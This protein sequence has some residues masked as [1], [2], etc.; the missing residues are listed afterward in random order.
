MIKQIKKTILKNPQENKID[1]LENKILELEN[2]LDESDIEAELRAL[3]TKNYSNGS[4][5]SSSDIM[6]VVGETINSATLQRLYASETW[7]FIVIHTIAKTISTLPI[8]LEKR[9]IQKQILTDD[10]GNETT[11][12]KETWIDASAEPEYDLLT[13]PNQSQ[14]PV[15]FYMLVLIDLLA[16]GQAFILKTKEGE[17]EGD[18]RPVSALEQQIRSHRK[19]NVHS[20]YRLNSSLV[21]PVF[22]GNTYELVGYSMQTEDGMYQFTLD[23]VIHIRLPN[24]TDAFNGL[25]PLVPV[26][27]HVLIDK[28]TSE[29]MIRFYKNGAR[30]GGVIK[31]TKKLTKDQ[32]T[33]LTRSFENDYTGKNNHHKTLIL[34]EGMDYQTIEQN[35][36]ETSL[37]EFSKFNKEPI[38]SAYGVPPVKVGLLDGATYANAL[39]QE[40][41]F[42]TDTVIPM[43][44]FIEDAFNLDLDIL[45]VERN[46]KFSFDTSMIEALQE[47]IKDKAETAILMSK[48][49]WSINEIRQEIWKKPAVEMGNQVPLIVS[50]LNTQ[51]M[52]GSSSSDSN[53]EASAPNDIETKIEAPQPDLATLSDIEP[54]RA[55]YAER[56]SQLVGILIASGVPLGQALTA[57]IEQVVAEGLAP[58]GEN[59]EAVKPNS[60]VQ[61][62]SQN[63]KASQ[64][65]EEKKNLN[66]KELKLQEYC[67]AL[68]GDGVKPLIEAKLKDVQEMFDRMKVLVLEDINKIDFKSLTKDDS[69][70]EGLP[71]FDWILQFVEIESVKVSDS[72]LAAMELGFSRT[73]PKQATSYPN[74]LATNWLKKR[75]AEKITGVTEVTREQI[76]KV[77]IDSFKAQDSSQELSLKIQ[78][79]F[80]E[81][82]QGRANT[83]ARTEVLTAVSQGQSIKVE[84]LSNEI[85]N[86][87]DNLL[88]TWITAQDGQVRSPLNGDKANHVILDGEEVAS[89]KSFSNGLDFPREAKGPAEEVINCRCSVIYHMK[90]DSN[91]ID[92]ILDIDRTQ[93]TF[94]F[95]FNF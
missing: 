67:K 72:D 8:K 71:L 17:I 70:I 73:L 36:G 75:A 94:D 2:K 58:G 6:G 79:T 22:D 95:M 19:S 41:I 64:D 28:F 15:E 16:T 77:I 39:V 29:H 61:D 12:Y 7:V 18:S 62:E 81:I 90:G 33:R 68:T 83:I 89:D 86:F 84:K 48:A 51:D 3:D 85:P 88:K 44:R 92:N 14:L 55:T 57:A 37:V 69:D 43:K 93:N 60:E 53:T 87:K 11:T 26:L 32:L 23:E 54:T 76:K 63:P 65:D 34:P 13:Y 80:D 82:K 49:G 21:E 20:M 40:K 10:K 47:S 45:N 38:L 27:K 42:W 31:T 1:I 78:E 66:E 52:Y 59:S 74:E 5:N 91:Y 30:L 24:P 25:A 46:L 4:S 9:K 50:T 35:P 56:L